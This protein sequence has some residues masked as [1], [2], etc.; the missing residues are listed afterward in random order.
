MSDEMRIYAEVGFNIFYLVVIWAVVILMAARLKTVKPEHYRVANLFKWAFFLLA[1]GDTGHVGFRVVAFTM[2]GLEN[3]TLLMGMGSLATAIT[4]TVFYVVMLYIWKV[5]FDGKFGWFEF[6]LLASVLVRVVVMA[7]PQN[8]WGSAVAR[9]FWGHLRNALL[10]FFGGGVLFLIL[11]DSIK[12]R[13]RLF[14]WVAYCIFFSYLFYVPV[15]FMVHEMP[16]LGMLMI[17]KTL[18]Y[19]AI[20]FLAYLNLWPR[21]MQQA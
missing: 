13:D 1:L 8:E 9:L 4:V 21:Q 17:P 18:M 2:S 7:F 6:A 16:E 5:R 10:T 19:M 12:A 3:P 14:R 20:A 15:V 11:R